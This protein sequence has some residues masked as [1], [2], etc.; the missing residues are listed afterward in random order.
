VFAAP[1]VVFLDGFHVGDV[2]TVFGDRD[3]DG[4]IQA[5]GIRKISP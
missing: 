3:I 5:F 1:G 2:V 4:T